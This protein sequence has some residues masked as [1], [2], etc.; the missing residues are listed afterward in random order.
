MFKKIFNALKE[1]AQKRNEE[2]LQYK[3]KQL[4]EK[5]EELFDVSVYNDE[6]WLYH[7][8]ELICPM[9]M[10]SLENPSAV[11]GEIR[12]HYINERIKE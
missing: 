4:N 10:F 2:K 12:N 8:G 11:V 1:S 3:R 7:D 5:A 9:R 6:L